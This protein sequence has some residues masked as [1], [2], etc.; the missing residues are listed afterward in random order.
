VQRLVEITREGPNA[1]DQQRRGARHGRLTDIPVDQRVVA[2]WLLRAP[3]AI[4]ERYGLRLER[5]SNVDATA[6]PS[7]RA[8]ENR[9]ARAA[10]NAISSCTRLPELCTRVALATRPMEST[11]ISTL[12][13]PARCS[14]AMQHEPE[15]ALL[16]RGV[17]NRRLDD[18]TEPIGN[19]RITHELDRAHGNGAVAVRNDGERQT[20]TLR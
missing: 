12:N 15:S 4:D 17:A 6:K 1:A 10:F 7:W 20:A 18:G 5:T 8:G 9:R 13:G 3:G 11:A 2:G 19:R 14:S 16:A